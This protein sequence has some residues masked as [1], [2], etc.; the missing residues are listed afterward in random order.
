MPLFRFIG[1]SRMSFLNNPFVLIPTSGLVIQLIVLVLLVYGYYQYRRLEF[2]RHGQAMAVATVLHLVVIFWVMI[3]SLV[4]AVIQ[5]YIVPKLLGI[6]SIITLVHVPLGILA[7]G[8]GVWF[9]AAWLIE[10]LRGCS[11]R[12][13][14]MLVTFVTWLATL[15]LGIILFAILYWSTLGL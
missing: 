15:T 12:R 9:S 1:N 3:P 2:K 11:N 7:V 10:G 13:K 8:L 4:L 14:L 5:E 6:V